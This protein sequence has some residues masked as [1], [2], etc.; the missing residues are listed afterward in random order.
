[1]GN[2][3]QSVTDNST[4]QAD[5]GFADGN[6]TGIDY[7]YD[8]NGNMMK[9]ANKEISNISYNHLNLPEVVTF[10]NGDHVRYLYDAAGIK[11]QKEAEISK[12]TTVTDYIAGKHYRNGDLE[13]FQHAEGRVVYNAGSFDYEYNLTDHLGNVRVTIKEGSADPI[14]STETTTYAFDNSDTGAP[15][16]L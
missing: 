2:Q 12:V 6:T 13:F 14:V 7:K 1:M 4:A 16:T 10:E 8:D 15:L 3:L 5:L 9:D 11:L